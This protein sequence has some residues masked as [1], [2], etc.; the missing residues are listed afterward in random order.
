LGEPG[1]RRRAREQLFRRLS[2]K[3]GDGDSNVLARYGAAGLA[4]SA[5]AACFAA[6]LSLRYESRLAQVASAPVVWAVLAVL[7]V[8]FFL[9]VI[10]V[11]A[12]P[13]HERRRSRE[14]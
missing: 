11:V 10:A 9:P 6:G 4:W 3:G 5:V 7:W 14:A 13:L 1:L 8:G 12:R 2:G